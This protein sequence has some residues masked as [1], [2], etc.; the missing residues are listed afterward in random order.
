MDVKIDIT[1][2]TIET[3]RLILRFWRE[4]DLHDFY[5]YASVE[6][7]GEMAGWSHHTSIEDSRKILQNFMLSKN[8]FAIIYKENGKVIGSLGLHESWAN[9][10]IRYT[11][12]KTKDIGYVLSKDYWGKGLMTEAVKAFINFCFDELK[13]DA[14]SSG[15]SLIN[16][17]SMRVIEK[18]GF[19]YVKT[20]DY[21]Y[22]EFELATTSKRYILINYK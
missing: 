3:D 16:N 6:G 9:D 20:S 11:G 8:E 18:C 22:H 14:V 15:H 10:D 19:E 2:H 1:Q 12:L 4:T 7:V 13:L 17:R 21:F 5:D